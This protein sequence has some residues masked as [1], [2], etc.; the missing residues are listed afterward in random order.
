[1]R[2]S[3][4]GAFVVHRAPLGAARPAS[5]ESYLLAVYPTLASSN[6]TRE[7]LDVLYR[8]R[9]YY[10]VCS[11][12]FLSHLEP[13]PSACAEPRAELPYLPR[14]ADGSAYYLALPPLVAAK[15]QGFKCERFGIDIRSKLFQ[16]T[17][18][19]GAHA[20]TLQHCVGRS[21]FELT[22]YSSVHSV[23]AH[24]LGPGPGYQ[25]PLAITR[26]PFAASTPVAVGNQLG[27][28]G[29]ALDAARDDFLAALLGVADG[30]L[31]EV[32][33]MVDAQSGMLRGRV[34]PGLWLN[35]W[36]GTG[37]FLRLRRPFASLSRATAII[38]MMRLVEQRNGGG[39]L[40]ELASRLGWKSALVKSFPATP[41]ADRIAH[42]LVAG[43]SCMAPNGRGVT[44]GNWSSW[45]LGATPTQIADELL[46]LAAGDGGGRRSK[47][48]S[49][50]S[51]S[52]WDRF[53]LYWGTSVCGG[54]RIGRIDGRAVS[55]DQLLAV[56]ACAL[57]RRSVVLAASANC[58]GLLHPEVVD[59]DSPAS[60]AE[61]PTPAA[62]AAALEGDETARS[63][64]SQCWRSLADASPRPPSEWAAR[65]DD[66]WRRASKFVR[67]DPWSARQLPCVLTAPAHGQKPHYLACDAHA[68]S[69]HGAVTQEFTLRATSS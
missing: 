54:K 1:M 59:Y 68:S 30:D 43:G 17:A 36:R 40:S 65:R 52:P 21:C 60:L 31:V 29:F 12:R 56:L 20:P 66:Y 27:K 32:E 64:L 67:S 2:R 34:S 33:S 11:A 16:P 26:Y 25:S 5:V 7:A 69:M 15:S 22:G 10:Y 62:A 42:V 45:A 47:H 28:R 51:A 48:S 24:W 50:R 46:A 53:L 41:W 55:W 39:V 19:L 38:E 6:A 63:L 61:W 44:A 37:V 49:P 9:N 3:K 8:S 57:G 4:P 14:G 13:R 58:N 23:S 18:D 35:A